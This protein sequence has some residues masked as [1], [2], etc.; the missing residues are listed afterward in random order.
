MMNM[1]DDLATF[2][3]LVE[4]FM[5]DTPGISCGKDFRTGTREFWNLF[6]RYARGKGFK[7]VLPPEDL[8]MECIKDM[9]PSMTIADNTMFG[10]TLWAP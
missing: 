4:S 5:F 3:E 6:T 1:M 9:I 8:L 7:R 2:M 10:I